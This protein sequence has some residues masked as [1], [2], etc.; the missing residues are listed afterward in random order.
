MST[1]RHQLDELASTFANGVLQAIRGA[2]IEELVAES[3]GG[4][5]A[6]K[7]GPGRPAAAVA[8][9]AAAPAA[10]PAAARGGRRRGGRLA[11]R[12]ADDIAS[13]ID[14][15][16]DAVKQ[17]TR[18]LRAEEIRSRLD[19]LPKEMPRPLKEALESGRLEKSGEK[20]ATTYFAK[21]GGSARPTPRRK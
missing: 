16:V 7:R 1:L 6:V 17:S 20:R 5:A 10:A 9:S 11:R 4:G 18:G 2:S 8:T 19:L 15:I 3:R 12:S 14:R 21:G 13:V